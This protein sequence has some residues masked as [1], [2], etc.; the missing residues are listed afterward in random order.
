MK[1]KNPLTLVIREAAAIWRAERPA[2]AE[3]INPLFRFDT[4][5]LRADDRGSLIDQAVGMSRRQA[6]Q[7]RMSAVTAPFEISEYDLDVD[8]L[9]DYLAGWP[10]AERDSDE[11]EWGALL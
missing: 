11:S 9:A 3:V 2:M 4:D 8:E 1:F 10:D 5:G 7:S 6:L